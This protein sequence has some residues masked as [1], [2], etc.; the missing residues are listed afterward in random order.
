[1]RP[2]C[3]E[4][5]WIVDEVVDSVSVHGGILVEIALYKASL[6]VVDG[7]LTSHDRVEANKWRVGNV[8][9]AVR[10]HVVFV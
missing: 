8:S 4:W 3:A 9:R 7:M 6:M 10:E 2:F 5:L 1:L